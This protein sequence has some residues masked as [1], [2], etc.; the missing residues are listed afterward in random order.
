[1]NISYYFAKCYMDLVAV[2]N[3]KAYWSEML[4]VE[5]HVYTFEQSFPTCVLCKK[6]FWLKSAMDLWVDWMSLL[7]CTSLSHSQLG[8]LTSVWSA[9]KSAG[10]WVAKAGLGWDGLSPLHVVFHPPAG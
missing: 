8:L 10:S 4:P 6:G 5:Y 9:A 7:T 2:S 3:T 1:M